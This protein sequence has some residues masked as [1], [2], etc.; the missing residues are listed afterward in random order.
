MKMKHHALHFQKVPFRLSVLYKWSVISPDLI[1]LAIQR[2]MQVCCHDWPSFFCI[3]SLICYASC[4]LFLTC[5]GNPSPHFQQIPLSKISALW[6]YAYWKRKCQAPSHCFSDAHHILSGSRLVAC[7][8]GC[9]FSLPAR[10]APLSDW[11]MTWTCCVV[12]VCW[13][14]HLQVQWRPYAPAE[15]LS[16]WARDQLWW[17]RTCNSWEILILTIRSY[18]PKSSQTYLS[19]FLHIFT[20]SELPFCYVWLHLKFAAKPELALPF[21]GHQLNLRSWSGAEMFVETFGEG[22]TELCWTQ[23][24]HV[25]CM[26][27]KGWSCHRDDKFLEKKDAWKSKEDKYY[28]QTVFLIVAVRCTHTRFNVPG[29]S[30]SIYLNS[31]LVGS[32][33]R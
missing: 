6:R 15:G 11:T 25:S 23:E 18:N 8:L 3:H 30:E 16:I 31:Y 28:I 13:V 7:D 20:H 33:D 5:T 27:L 14:V 19:F 21:N 24:T 2:L 12:P 29:F 4:Y 26:K 10:W 32:I 1:F 22:V 17:L 9:T